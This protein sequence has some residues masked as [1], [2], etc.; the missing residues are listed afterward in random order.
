MTLRLLS[1]KT[2]WLI[3][4]IAL[5]AC[6]VA[7]ASAATSVS[8]SGITWTFDKNYTTGQFANGDYWVVGP[9]KIVGISPK[10]SNL[11]DS[12]DLHGSVVNPLPDTSSPYVQSWDSR[13][14]GGTTYDRSRNV[15]RQLPLTL[16]A[17]NSLVSVNSF[18]SPNGNGLHMADAAV[19]TVL[20]SAPPSGSF[21]P[22]YAGTDKRIPGNVADLNLTI[23]RSLAPV[24]GTP[25]FSSFDGPFNQPFLD[26]IAQWPNSSVKAANGGPH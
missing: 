7:P 26:I 24:S 11:S 1:E 22:P 21:R 13:V 4:V 17:G 6:L 14:G 20:S 15:A 2:I 8:R 12:T 18:A 3:S 19:L 5:L 25:S 16:A 10:D 9:V 23:F